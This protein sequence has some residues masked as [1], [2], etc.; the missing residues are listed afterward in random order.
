MQIMTAVNDVAP[1]T[2]RVRACVC[3][4]GPALDKTS[5]IH[6]LRLTFR[7]PYIVLRVETIRVFRAE[8]C[9]PPGAANVAY[10]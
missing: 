5:L 10:T 3:V 8:G 9:G 7:A 2:V 1:V 6:S 4:C